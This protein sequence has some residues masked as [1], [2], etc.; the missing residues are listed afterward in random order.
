LGENAYK[1]QNFYF[2]NLHKV[3]HH[4][5]HSKK[6]GKCPPVRCVIDTH[7]FSGMMLAVSRLMWIENEKTIGSKVISQSTLLQHC[8]P[9]FFLAISMYCL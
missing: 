9:G 4:Y 6:R 1:I 8:S 2:P 5:D 7:A 3:H